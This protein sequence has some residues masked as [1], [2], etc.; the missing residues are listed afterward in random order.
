MLCFAGIGA[1]CAGVDL[2][3][4]AFA[5]GL[6]IVAMGTA[7]GV[8]S[9]G[10]F[11]PAVSLAL[12]MTKR[13]D[14]TTM[15]AYWF[16]Q[17]GGAALGAFAIKAT[18]TEPSV[19]AGGLGLPALATGID[20]TKGAIL[21]MIGTFVLVLTIFGT[22]VH[23]KAPKL[24]ALAIGFAIIAM[25][26]AFGPMTGTGINPARWFGPAVVLSDFKDALAYTLAP[27]IGAGSAA[28]IYQNFLA[29]DIDESVPLQ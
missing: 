9:G 19:A 14:P 2:I 15:F 11:N 17:L 25:I 26:F 12:L 1:I 29:P 24:G 21:E 16:A 8:V 4:V 5:H 22:A 20:V 27:L 6:A 7:L 3:G 13:I 23:K 18:F 10:H 28:L